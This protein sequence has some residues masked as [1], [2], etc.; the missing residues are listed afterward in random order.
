MFE[1]RVICPAAIRRISH[2]SWLVP[3]SFV[4]RVAMYHLFH[5]WGQT[6]QAMYIHRVGRPANPGPHVCINNE[7]YI[8]V[9]C[10]QLGPIRIPARWESC[11]MDADEWTVC[12]WFV[13]QFDELGQ[14]LKK[15]NYEISFHGGC[16]GFKYIQCGM[17]LCFLQKQMY[18]L[19]TF[20]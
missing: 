17:D 8:S 4:F 18:F 15:I 20:L 3:R 2:V 10:R 19:H 6:V 16:I 9:L 11:I 13:R 5:S 12:C 14:L 7:I 1:Q